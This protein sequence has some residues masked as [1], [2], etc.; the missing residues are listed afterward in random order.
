[1]EVNETVSKTSR[2]YKKVIEVHIYL[3]FER[4]TYS[5]APA[6]FFCLPVVADQYIHHVY[7]GDNADHDQ[8]YVPSRE[9]GATNGRCSYRAHNPKTRALR[10]MKS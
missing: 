5:L 2:K 9:A 1:M 7:V 6:L 8:D 3:T 10:L 4:E